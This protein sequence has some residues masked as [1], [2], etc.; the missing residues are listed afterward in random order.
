MTL[1]RCDSRGL[2]T[3]AAA[4]LLCMFFPAG[5]QAQSLPQHLSAM[6]AALFAELAPELEQA[7][8][9]DSHGWATRKAYEAL[10]AQ[11]IDRWSTDGFPEFST[12][13]ELAA[14]LELDPAEPEDREK[15]AR[16]MAEVAELGSEQAFR[17]FAAREGIALGNPAAVAQSLQPIDQ[18]LTAGWEGLEREA[19]LT[20]PD[21]REVLL[22][23]TPERNLFAIEV[24]D[25]G[26][27][28][29]AES[30]TRLS[31]ELAP[32]FQAE[33]DGLS[34]AL[35]PAQEAIRALDSQDLA[36][37]RGNIFGEWTDQHGK[38][39]VIEPA[40]GAAEPTEAEPLPE[41]ESVRILREIADK[42]SRLEAQQ[43]GTPVFVWEN[44]ETGEREEQARF[45]RLSDPWVYLG[46]EAP[47]AAEAAEERARLEEEIAALKQQL[48]SAVL[49]AT[50]PALPAPDPET[51]VRGLR[52]TTQRHTDS[53]FFTYDE[54]VLQNGTVKARRTLRN[55]ADISGLPE[56]VI[57]QLVT[58]YHP[59]EW[60]EMTIARDRDS[61]EWRLEGSEYRLHVTYS[62]DSLEVASIHTPYAKPLTLAREGQ[63]AP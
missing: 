14:A 59:P 51:G 31:G 7:D 61:G 6:A 48:D 44:P 27:D 10:L 34:Y 20:S 41:P 23:W 40:E 5:A 3:A 63:K 8:P 28:Y 35:A 57:A 30:L 4:A 2:R 37:A 26:T 62:G 25:P 45:K 53:S 55:L 60:I 49:T 56:Q 50:A 12:L 32:D 18:A 43:G 22:D 54:A 21:G 42:Q 1:R 29:R 24:A 13:P 11:R 47:G 33:G 17:N 58:E 16:F 38:L 15:L 19:R 39:W 52:V 9:D 36:E 46:E